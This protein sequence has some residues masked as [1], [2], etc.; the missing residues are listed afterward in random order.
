MKNMF[1]ILILTSVISFSK[2][3]E[4]EIKKGIIS[5]ISSQNVYVKFDNTIGIAEGDTLFTVSGNKSNAALIVRFISSTSCA[6]EKIVDKNLKVNDELIAYIKIEQTEVKGEITVDTKKPQLSESI[7]EVKIQSYSSIK[8]INSGISGRISTQSYSNFTN[9]S[10]R[11]NNQ[12]WRHSVRLNAQNIENTGLSFSTYSIFAYKADDWKQISSNIGRALKIYDLNLGYKFDESTRLWLGRYLNRRISNISAVDGL[13]IERDFS[14]FTIGLVGGSRPDFSDFGYNFRLFE[15]GVYINKADTLGSGMM[16]NTLSVFEQTNDFKTDRRFIYLQ[17]SNNLIQK[18]S[19][20]IS[21]EIDLYKKI[22]DREENSPS[23]TSVF[24]S[25]RYT[26]VRELSFSLSYDARQNVIYYET[27]KSFIDSVFENETRQGF[28]FR[29]NIKPL[30]NLSLGLNYGYRYRKSDLKPN[31]NFGGNI[32]YTNIP[33]LDVSTNVS[34]SRL[35]SS[36]I[37]SNLYGVFIY[38]TIDQIYLDI[39]IGLRLTEYMLLQNNGKYN[40]KSIVVDASSSLLNPVYIS[41]G[42]EGI[43]EQVRTSGR[44]LIDLSLRF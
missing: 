21:S 29:T 20:F 44:I 22:L 35:N 19:F 8:K 4:R 11:G 26:P 18:T 36:Y 38:K 34:F 41:L 9:Y 5:F 27:F 6:G 12:R 40:E 17:H 25:A 2:S 3:D 7:P 23:V 33:L 10:D 15:Y 32:S 43:F 30:R 42:Y 37:E 13:Q 14:S 28:R 39:S 16:D 1:L 24:V 31:T